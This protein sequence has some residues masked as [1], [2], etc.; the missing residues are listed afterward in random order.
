M[1][2]IEFDEP[3]TGIYR[4]GKTPPYLYYLIIRDEEG[5]LYVESD[6]GPVRASP[7]LF[8]FERPFSKKQIKKNI[9]RNKPKAEFLRKSLER[10]S[11]Q[12]KP[13]FT[14][15]RN[16]GGAPILSDRPFLK[17]SPATYGEASNPDSS[18][19]P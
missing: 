15:V 4:F 16:C 9:R 5:N 17:D 18:Q 6:E 7:Y 14:E 8:R 10:L 13:K 11:S 12:T 1:G 19:K 3:E 2:S